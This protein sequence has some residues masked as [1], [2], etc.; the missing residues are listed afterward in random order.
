MMRT[1][2]GRCPRLEALNF[3]PS[4]VEPPD[5]RGP[6]WGPRISLNSKSPV[7]SDFPWAS[8][9]TDPR[10]ATLRCMQSFRIATAPI[11]IAPFL[12]AKR[13]MGADPHRGNDAG[14]SCS[15]GARSPAPRASRT[16]RD[17][18]HRGAWE[19]VSPHPCLCIAGEVLQIPESTEKKL[20]ANPK[21]E[22]LSAD[23][24]RRSSPNRLHSPTPFPSCFGGRDV[25]KRFDGLSANSACGGASRSRS[26]RSR[27]TSWPRLPV[28][29]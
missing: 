15:R 20:S 29:E 16:D 17:I 25:T 18:A 13:L 1:G 21:S 22:H 5:Q 23:K 26:H 8:A 9:V 19:S 11:Q 24:Q 6:R 28:P 2:A 10:T 4:P 3:L 12:G 14:R 7:S 27:A